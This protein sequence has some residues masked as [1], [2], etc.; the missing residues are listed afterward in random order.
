MESRSKEAF[1]I[2]PHP[3]FLYSVRFHPNSDDLVVT[4]GYDKIVR[5]WFVNC[6]SKGKHFGDKYG[7]LLQELSGHVGYVNALCFSADGD[8]LYSADSA[9]RIKCW[10][11]PLK[12]E[13]KNIGNKIIN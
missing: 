5:V 8:C 10:A 13:P 1:K 4:G 9:G 7:Q 6:S 12:S 2:L 11:T 3:S